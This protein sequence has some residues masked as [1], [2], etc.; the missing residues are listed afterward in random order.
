M[1]SMVMNISLKHPKIYSS[2]PNTRTGNIL[3]V[4]TRTKNTEIHTALSTRSP[5]SQLRN[6]FPSSYRNLIAF[7][8]ATSC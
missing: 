4:T 6:V 2:S 3:N 8:R 1:M 5:V 7:E